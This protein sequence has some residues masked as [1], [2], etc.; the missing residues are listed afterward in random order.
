MMNRV[1]ET[2]VPPLVSILIPAYNSEKWIQQAIESALAQTWETKEIIVVDDGSTDQTLRIAKR[3]E[4]ES[5]IITSQKNGGAASARNKA[6]TLSKGDFIQ[7]LD[8]DDLLSPEKISA[9]MKIALC[10]GTDLKLYSGPYGLFFYRANRARFIPNSLW[11]DL[12]P[13]EWLIINFSEN[14][15]MNPATW[16]VSR[17][18]TDKAGPWNGELSR[19]DDGEYFARIV[20]LSE[21][22]RFVPEAKCFYRQSG[23]RQLSRNISPKALCSLFL[24]AKLKIQT[25]LTLEDSVRTKKASIALLQEILPLFYTE[26]EDHIKQINNLAFELGGRLSR[27]MLGWKRDSLLRILGPKSGEK[28]WILICKIKMAIFVKYDEMLFWLGL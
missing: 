16:L 20:A 21:G 2:T 7:W 19:D 13:V 9:Q 27:P 28:F 4:S 22:I 23:F 11:Q 15:W 17:R 3:F 24:S 26:N 12:S 5:V 8:A 6:F 10:E 14:V 1:E 18:L 25:L